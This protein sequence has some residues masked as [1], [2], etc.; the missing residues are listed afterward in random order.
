MIRMKTKISEL[1][2]S[3]VYFDK[4]AKMFTQFRGVDRGK[5]VFSD[6]TNFYKD[7]ET[8]IP[9]IKKRAYLAGKHVF[10]LLC[11]DRIHPQ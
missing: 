3:E 5:Y 9:D 2:L 8:V 4:K 6:T 7:A 1:E 10:D 11:N